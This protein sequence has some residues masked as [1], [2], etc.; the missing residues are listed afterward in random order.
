MDNEAEIEEEDLNGGLFSITLSSSDSD[1]S[2]TS[3]K[4]PRDFQSEADF[5]AILKT[6]KPKVETG[7]LYKTLKLPINR[8]TKPESQ[9]ILHAVEELYFLRRYEEALGVVERALE[10]ELGVEIR[11][12]LGRYRG[13]CEGKVGS[14]GRK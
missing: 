6:W 14:L 3:P 4:L 5:Q 2:P 7:D 10:G 12:V 9:V 8:P 1:T 11:G 13:K